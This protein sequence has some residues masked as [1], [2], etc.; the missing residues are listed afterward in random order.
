MKQSQDNNAQQNLPKGYTPKKGKP[1]P[2]RK[3]AEQHGGTFEARFAP[4]KSWGE[5]RKERKELKAK[6]SSE[7]WRAYKAKQKEERKQRT[8]EAQ[9]AMDRGEEKYL[10]D[11]DKGPEKRFVRDFVD[12]RRYTSNFVMP[13]ALILLL[14]LFIGQWAPKFASI[15]SMAAMLMMLAFLVEGIVLGRSA[16]KATR[17]KFPD[18]TLRGSSIGFYAYSRATQPRRWRTPKPRVALGE[19]VK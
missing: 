4:Q 9:A 8:R 18:T 13:V 19:K 12:S 11:R 7:E 14:V 6:M 17:E 16:S 2:K 1:T 3:E 15:V 5:S 10:L